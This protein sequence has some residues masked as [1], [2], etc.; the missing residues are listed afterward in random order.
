MMDDRVNRYRFTLGEE[1]AHYVLHREHFTETETVKQACAVQQELE[2]DLHH[3]ERNAK[4]F[5]AAL[6][7]PVDAVRG[8]ANTIYATI[9]GHVGFGNA[10]A[11]R[12]KLTALLAQQF[13]VSAQAMRIR[14]QNYAC[15]VTEALDR[16][17]AGHHADLWETNR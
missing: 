8:R 5:S 6:L 4:R 12:N 14:L 1:V 7:M 3:M 15:G 9:V 17:L 2:A 16:A 13:R 10:A 11:V